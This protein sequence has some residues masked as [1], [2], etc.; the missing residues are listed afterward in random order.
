LT[1]IPAYRVALVTTATIRARSGP[2]QKAVAEAVLTE[3]CLTSAQAITLFYREIVPESA[4][5]QNG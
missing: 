3:F 1:L 2:D 4:P 5:N